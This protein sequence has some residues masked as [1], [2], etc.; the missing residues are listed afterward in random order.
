MPTR[1]GEPFRRDDRKGWTIRWTDYGAD[2]EPVRRKRQLQ[3]VTKD[4][5][6][7][8]RSKLVA[9]V[10][11]RR[12]GLARSVTLAT[13]A[14]DDLFPL[15]GPRMRPKS[16]E[17]FSG[18]VLRAAEHFGETPLGA[19]DREA[20]EK[21]LALLTTGSPGRRPLHP[22]TVRNYRANLS[23]AWKLAI[24]R[25]A[26]HE[27]PWRDLAL[28]KADERVVPFLTEEQLE[29]LYRLVPA[30]L[31]PLT[32]F[33]GE[34]G[35]RLGEALAMT[36]S[37]VAEDKSRV[38]VTTGRRRRTRDVP[39]S[40]RARGVLEALPRGRGPLVFATFKGAFPRGWRDGWKEAVTHFGHAS[41]RIHDLRHTRA[42]LFVRAGVPVPS[43]SR[44]LG[45]T[46]PAMVLTRYGHHAPENELD[47][48][49][50]R[51]EAA[52][53][54]KPRRPPA[55]RARTSGSPRRGGPRRR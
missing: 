28:P 47:D 41:F 6:K 13:F 54:G 35:M 25:Q 36:W 9:A 15:V 32:I 31:R 19:I 24:S 30:R 17:A 48:A 51:L 11:R 39:L 50:Q 55:R 1:E 29:E 16:F 43:V 12:M 14:A 3:H 37:N 34:T 38:T 7:R 18:R 42:S 44:W 22:L 26:A 27:N 20:A 5:A 23:V 46:T 2:G 53:R 10:V 33:L 52:R 49:L 45:H 40:T 8:I 21:Y 4:E